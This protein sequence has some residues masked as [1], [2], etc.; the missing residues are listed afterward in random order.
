MVGNLRQDASASAGGGTAVMPPGTD[1]SGILA[2]F[3]PPANLAQDVSQ[4]ERRGSE[5][6]NAQPGTITAPKR[7]VVVLGV[8][9]CLA[10]LVSNVFLREGF[11]G[12]EGFYGVTALNML[13]SPAYSLRPSF[14]PDGNFMAD[15]DGFAH[16]PF[17]SYL[18]ALALWAS[19]SGLSTN[20]RPAALLLA[21]PEIIHAL[22]FGLL[23]FFVFRL[24]APFDT[25][26]ATFTVLLLVASP[27]VRSYYSQLEAEP[28]MTTAGIASLYFILHSGRGATLLRYVFIGGLCL[29]LA[30]AL[31]LWLCGPLGLASA[32]ALLLRLGRPILRRQA[33]IAVSVFAVG[34]VLPMA[35]HLGAIA[36]FYPADLTFWWRNIYFGVFTHAGISGSKIA[37]AGV[38][39]DWVHPVWYYIPALYRDHFFLLPTFLLG[40]ASFLRE[41]KARRAQPDDPDPREIRP[42]ATHLVWILLIG[43]SGLLPLSLISVKEPL[44]VLSC[45]IFLYCLAGLCLA[46]LARRISL[47]ERLRPS[48]LFQH[49]GLIPMFGVLVI[50]P[51]L[52]ALHIQQG[53]ITAAFV[54]AHS[55]VIALFLML[56]WIMKGAVFERGTQVAC[57]GTVIGAFAFGFLTARPQDK[58]ITRIIGPRIASNSPAQLS[59][60]ASN[61]K[62]FQ[63]STFRSGC[64]WHEL[65]LQQ[66]P[67]A[68]L[69]SSGFAAVR[70]FILDSDDLQNPAIAPWLHWLESHAKEK[71]GELDSTLGKKSGLRVFV[72]QHRD[73][74]QGQ[75][76]R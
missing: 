48:G 68:L 30:F 40:A 25:K 27:A 46:A 19:N 52:Y 14:R 69:A 51:L 43:L 10:L 15:K 50:I 57:V 56:F 38:S 49:A 16:P 67:E 28:L 65:D 24:M 21:G 5:A 62:S 18:Y 58:V 72:R 9:T 47:P 71:T 75:A 76:G 63:Y 39:S 64:Y 44:Y 12:D 8:L 7:F 26:A 55:L 23:L 36:V 31:K 66:A 22:S 42:R 59:F 2:E 35:I 11:S 4:A 70:A 73:Q 17:N 54:L 61:Y 13:R 3:A 53:K 33:L 1:G 29:G 74:L 37:G 41:I 20:S 60:I 32:A 34:F 45:S 6:I